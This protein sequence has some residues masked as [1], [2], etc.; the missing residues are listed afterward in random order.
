MLLHCHSHY[1]RQEVQAEVSN[2]VAKRKLSAAT[3]L[4]SLLDMYAF[5]ECVTPFPS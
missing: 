4:D 1:H 3:F 2:Q 5:C